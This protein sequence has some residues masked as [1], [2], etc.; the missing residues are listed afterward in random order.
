[1]NQKI[2]NYVF[3]K[4]S[5]LAAGFGLFISCS[6]DVE[7]TNSE[8]ASSI[9]GVSLSGTF[10]SRHSPPTTPSDPRRIKL[11]DAAIY[12]KFAKNQDNHDRVI[13]D[14]ANPPVGYIEEPGTS[15]WLPV[16]TKYQLGGKTH[17]S[18]KL[19]YIMRNDFAEGSHLYTDDVAQAERAKAYGS[20]NALWTFLFNTNTNG[21]SPL[22]LFRCDLVGRFSIGFEPEKFA[23]YG[24][25]VEKTIGYVLR[26]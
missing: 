11:I 26:K 18:L 2:S 17:S 19:I 3:V 22:Y 15:F 16:D 21:G 25:K 24:C 5:I 12:F 13:G 1:M 10:A 6:G 4:S 8:D 20:V 14:K 23:P 7:K 9:D